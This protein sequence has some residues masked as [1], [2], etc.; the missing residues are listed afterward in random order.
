MIRRVAIVTNATV[1]AGPGAVAKLLEAEYEVLCHDET[2]VSEAN[3]TAF[4]SSHPGASTY[5]SKAP[6]G[7][8][9]HAVKAWGRLD[10][11]VSNDV[12]P[13]QYLPIDEI[14]TAELRRAIDALLMTPIA[15]VSKAA[16]QMK[17]QSK[18]TI[19]MVTSAAPSRPD[20][21]FS[22]YS[23]VRAGASAFSHAAARE[24]APHGINVNAIAPNFLESETYYPAELWSTPEGKDKLKKLLPAGRLGTGQELGALIVFLASGAADFITGEVIKFTGGWS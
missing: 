14:E 12:F 2:F 9:A 21:G 19:V 6:T 16:A 23:S 11:L 5:G 1:Y 10:L 7:A 18:G 8:V 15:M 17:R 3:R 13:L 20:P 4:E 22:I 24:L